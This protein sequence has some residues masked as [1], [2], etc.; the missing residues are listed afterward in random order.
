M[1]LAR[2]LAARVTTTAMAAAA[3]VGGGAVAAAAPATTQLRPAS[4]ASGIRVEADTMGELQVP[5]DKYWGAQ[6]QRSLINFPIGNEQDR[7]PKE[8]MRG[9]C[10]EA[11]C[12]NTRTARAITTPDLSWPC[13]VW[14]PQEVRGQGEHGVRPP[15]QGHWQRHRAGMRRAHRRQAG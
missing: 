6:T 15:A 8:V 2:R 4:T 9:E 7:M 10:F 13:S 3:A 12:G 5:S 1:A 11:P 14:H